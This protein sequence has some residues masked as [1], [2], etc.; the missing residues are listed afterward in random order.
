MPFKSP[1]GESVLS[2]NLPEPDD[3][4]SEGKMSNSHSHSSTRPESGKRPDPTPPPLPPAWLHLPGST[5]AL[6]R[7]VVDCVRHGKHSVSSLRGA[8]NP[9]KNPLTWKLPPNFRLL[10]SLATNQ[11]QETRPIRGLNVTAWQANVSHGKDGE[12]S[13]A[14]R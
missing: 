10:I 11:K 8:G 13:P 9:L 1:G 12:T 4:S 3:F 5:S 14:Q 7:L 6:L 2:E